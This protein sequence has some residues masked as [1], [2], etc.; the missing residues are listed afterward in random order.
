VTKAL[1][2]YARKRE[3]IQ[4]R[5]VN[6]IFA[7]LQ[8]PKTDGVTPKPIPSPFFVH[9]FQFFIANKSNSLAFDL[10]RFRLYRSD[11]ILQKMAPEKVI[12]K[13]ATTLVA[14]RQADVSSM[15]LKV[16]ERCA[17]VRVCVCVCVPKWF[18]ARDR[19]R[20]RESEKGESVR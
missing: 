15:S 3:E 16:K 13:P 6:A 12:L 14:K 4:A 2:S 11:K 8:Q 20:V 18:H 10:N 19:K 7:V 17:C 9:E 5:C 1:L